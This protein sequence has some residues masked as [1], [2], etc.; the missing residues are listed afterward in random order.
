MKTGIKSERNEHKMT[1]GDK[2][3]RVQHFTFHAG[4][5]H[6]SPA[7]CGRKAAFANASVFAKATT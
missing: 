1:N 6:F 4:L 5:T 3:G 7:G 2:L